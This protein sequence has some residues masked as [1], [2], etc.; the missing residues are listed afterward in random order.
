MKTSFV[1]ELGG[2][3]GKWAHFVLIRAFLFDSVGHAA[4]EFAVSNNSTPPYSAQTS[5]FI[6][7]EVASINYLGQQLRAW[8]I[9]HDSPLIWFSSAV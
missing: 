9:S 4:I 2:K 7:S 6:R 8:V 3:S 1:V 5:F